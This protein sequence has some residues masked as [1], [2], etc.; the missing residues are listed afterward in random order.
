[1]IKV[2]AKKI[3]IAPRKWLFSLK[4]WFS[5]VCFSLGMKLLDAYIAYAGERARVYEL[6]SACLCTPGMGVNLSTLLRAREVP[7]M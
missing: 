6:R 1:M 3:A 2:K 5:I 4:L 7:C